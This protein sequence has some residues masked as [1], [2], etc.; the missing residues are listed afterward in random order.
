MNRSLNNSATW[1]SAAMIFAVVL[2]WS[3]VVMAGTTASPPAHCG[4]YS[5]Y[6][7]M[8]IEGVH[9]N[10]VDLLQPLYISAAD[11]STFADL[12]RAA[13]D[14]GL[15][16]ELLSN[17]DVAALKAAKCPVILH[18]KN[19][20]DAPDYNHFVLCVPGCDGRIALYNAPDELVW[21][22]GDELSALWDGTG[23]AVSASPT[24]VHIRS[25][26]PIRW[27][28]GAGC[29]GVIVLIVRGIGR[30][31]AR[32]IRWAWTRTSACV[33]CVAVAAAA[34][35]HIA[36]REGFWSQ[37]PAV[38]AIQSAHFPNDIRIINVAEA[39]SLAH[40]GV[41]FV[42]ART[43]SD[44]DVG[45]IPG[46]INIPATTSP[47]IR[48][49]AMSDLARNKLIVVYCAG[50]SCPFAAFMARRLSSDGFTNVLVFAGG[51]EAWSH[52]IASVAMGNRKVE[53]EPVSGHH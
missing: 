36:F 13:A 51:W 9:V 24:D 8:Q 26:A 27:G 17:L 53:N 25:A 6:T 7:A 21:T 2:V 18:V 1:L 22:S 49:K 48:Q 5:L 40:D 3:P 31:K 12:R 11:G 10:L 37:G 46:A 42:D 39:R 35:Q 50:E 16:A 14:H 33:A 41:C 34:I 29:I 28:G 52:P 30:R 43:A 44:F 15:S 45:S 4:I 47:H 32:T 20:W 19:E 38:S 23:L